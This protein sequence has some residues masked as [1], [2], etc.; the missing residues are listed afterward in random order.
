[1]SHAI[2][3]LSFQIDTEILQ[4]Y[5]IKLTLFPSHM[6]RDFMDAVRLLDPL[7]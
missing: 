3:M 4:F 2:H 7:E 5:Y 6:K 1:M